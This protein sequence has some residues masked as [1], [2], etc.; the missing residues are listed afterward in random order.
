MGIIDKSR[1]KGSAE[2]AGIILSEEKLE[3]LDDYASLLLEWNEKINLTAI[4]DAQG[5][6]QKHFL[7]CI[8]LASLPQLGENLVD[9]GTG[10][11]FPGLVIK[12][13][14]PEIQL[15]LMEPTGKRVQFLQDVCQ[16]LG[17]KAEFIKERGEEA[18]RKK[19]RESYKTATARAVA[20]LPALCEYCLPLV[21]TGGYFISMKADAAQEVESAKNA[22]EKL[23]GRV[24][25]TREYSL[26]GGDKRSLIIIKKEKETPPQYPRA[27]GVIKKRPL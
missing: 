6:E 9:V 8:Y 2:A 21:K 10:A 15:S 4:T 18:A 16:K 17:I 25:E 24:E 23:G 11:G 1:L 5:I 22:L 13:V 7:D 20:A 19:W 3:Q 12:I 26:P 27:G 14:K